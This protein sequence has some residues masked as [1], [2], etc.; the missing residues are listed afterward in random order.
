MFHN[1]TDD[2]ESQALDIINREDSMLDFLFLDP[3][4]ELEC[5]E[6]IGN[7]QSVIEIFRWLG[8]LIL[9]WASFVDCK[10]AD[11]L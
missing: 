5:V 2:G 7:N 6:L 10:L 8:K 11:V 9:S 1:E 4:H 3:S